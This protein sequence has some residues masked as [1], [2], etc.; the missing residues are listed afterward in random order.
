VSG[1]EA[2]GVVKRFGGLTALDGVD[3]TV[4][5][6]EIVALLGPNGA[7]KSTLLRIL[8]TALLPDDGTC[9]VAGHDVA[10]E[11]AAVRRVIGF[12]SGDERSWYWRISGRQNLEFFAVL[13]GVARRH[14]GEHA[15]RMLTAVGLDDVADRRVDRYS[16]GMRARLAVARALL[17]KPRVVL[18]DE[19]FRNLDPAAAAGA[20]DLVR[21]LASA[22]HAAVLLATHDLHEA[23][24]LASRVVILARGRVAARVDGGA[25]AAQLESTFL[26][27][28]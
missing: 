18:M 6:G 13:H 2:R 24:T 17:P 10:I 26:A 4:G 28:R 25:D 20:R 23:S 21:E 12:V 15:S 3:L 27:V 5:E 1:I 11:D 9:H 22:D 14:A 19:P 7:G 16:S 8:A